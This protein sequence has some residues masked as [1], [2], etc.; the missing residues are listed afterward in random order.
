MDDRQFDSLTRTLAA[1]TAC[2]RQA[3]RLP[4]SCALGLFSTHVVAG[5][6]EVREAVAKGCLKERKRCQRDRRCCSGICKKHRCRRAPGQLT[7]T[8]RRNFCESGVD[9]TVCGTANGGDPCACVVT[10]SGVSFCGDIASVECVPCLGS[11]DC[12]AV[13][14]PGSVC[15]RAVGNCLCNDGSE[16][17]CVPP[18]VPELG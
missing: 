4:V 17:F 10:T 16:T 6:F 2:R 18:C 12:A 9:G 3:L 1:T 14:G 13:A 7:C 5:R 11:G 15:V 8:I